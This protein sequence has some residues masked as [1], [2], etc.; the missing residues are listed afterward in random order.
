[1]T[2]IV[3]KRPYTLDNLVCL[4]GKKFFCFIYIRTRFYCYQVLAVDAENN[5]D[6][7]V[8]EYFVTAMTVLYENYTK[9]PIIFVAVTEKVDLKPN[10]MRIFLERFHLPRLNVEQRYKLLIWYA[11]V[12]GLSI[13]D[14]IKDGKSSSQ[15]LEMYIDLDSTENE[16]LNSYIKDMLYR[17]ASKT[18]TF[19]YGD[20]DTLMH[21]AMRESYLKQTKGKSQISSD[22]NLSLVQ[23]E[24]FNNALGEHYLLLNCTSLIISIN[25]CIIIMVHRQAHWFF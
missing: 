1:M 20:L 21:F 5:E 8:M 2:A 23:E 12:M 7:R 10:M 6:F 25:G 11:S 4:L 24:D 17:V 16:Y 18:E 3:D 19:V 9:H 22:P 14:F 15:R 13:N